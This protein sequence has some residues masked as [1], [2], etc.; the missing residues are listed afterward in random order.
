MGFKMRGWDRDTDGD[1]GYLKVSCVKSSSV[2]FA[3]YTCFAED[4]SG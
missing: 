1:D 2:C 4:P 3:D